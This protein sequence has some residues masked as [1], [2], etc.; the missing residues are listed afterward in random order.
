MK[1]SEKVHLED[2]RL[3]IQE[4]HDFNATLNKAAEMRSHGQTDMGDSKLVGLIPMTLWA[5][6]A[7]KWGVR[8]DDK[9]GMKDVIARELM[10]PDNAYFRVWGGRF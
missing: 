10:N 8:A 9:Q 7:K 1:L 4:T 6:W 3:I 2:G 5:E